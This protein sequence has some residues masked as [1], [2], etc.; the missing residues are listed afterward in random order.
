MLRRV[1][2]GLTILSIVLLLAGCFNPIQALKDFIVGEEQVERQPAENFKV[3]DKEPAS[4]NM[5][6]K[7]RETVLYYKDDKG[8]LIPVMRDIEWQEGIA[9]AAVG[10][11]IEGPE[12]MEVAGDA[13]LY[14]TIPAGTKILGLTIRGGLAKIDL[15]GEVFNYQDARDEGLMV[16]SIVYTL[17]EFNTVDE[18][19]FMF[20]GEIMESLKFGTRVDE[21]IRREDINLIGDTNDAKVVV[22]FYRENDKGFQ[23]FVPATIGVGTAGDGMDVA[24]KCLLEGPPEGSNLHS[25]IPENSKILGMGVKNGI[26]YINFEKGIFDYQGSDR[27]GENIVKSVTLTLREYP[28]VVGVQFLVDGEFARLPSGMVLDNTIDVPVFANIY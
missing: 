13:G 4:G 25:D 17:T 10:R 23:Y 16:K 19:Q 22:Y 27:V 24:M 9:R 7:M 1:M 20:D 3:E 28:S 21:P 8:Y 11:I 2:L 5:D 15:S 18:V 26:V 12:G 6:V 14:P